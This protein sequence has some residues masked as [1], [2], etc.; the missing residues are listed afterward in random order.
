MIEF[1]LGDT[2]GND[3][4]S[5]PVV[6]L[7]DLGGSPVGNTAECILERPELGGGG[8]QPLSYFSS[9]KFGQCQANYT[10]GPA[11][12]VDWIDAITGIQY[13]STTVDEKSAT[14]PRLP[15]SRLD[16]TSTT[17]KSVIQARTGPV[18]ASTDY[19]SDGFTVTQYPHL[20]PYN[21]APDQAQPGETACGD[22]NIGDAT[23]YPVFVDRVSC[24]RGVQLLQS[25]STVSPTP[26][27]YCSGVQDGLVFCTSGISIHEPLDDWTASTIHVRAVPNGGALPPTS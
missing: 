5:M 24:T 4:I 2:N 14:G 9:M 7:T 15:V 19:L 13:R 3:Q 23:D 18:E 20:A 12:S 11:Q 8:Y 22:Q 25:L 1:P 10:L 27:W 26:G 6:K 17:N 21:P 16:L